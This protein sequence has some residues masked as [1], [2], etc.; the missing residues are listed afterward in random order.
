MHKSGTS[1][2]NFCAPEPGHR[3]EVL[4]ANTWRCNLR[5]S[6]CFVDQRS[7]AK[8][9]EGM[10]RKLA[11]QVIDALDAGLAHIEQICVHFYGGEPLLHLPAIEAMVE[12]SEAKAPGRFTFAITTNGAAASERAVALLGAAD[13]QIVLSVDGPGEVHD[14]CRRT[15]DDQP[16]HS[17]VLAFLAAIRERT[18]CRVRGSAVVRSGWSLAQASAYLRS[19]R[20]D[21]IK[22]QAV[23]AA[24]GAPY[25]L[26]P[27]EQQAYLRDLEAA[28][29]QVIAELEAGRQPKDDRFT[30]RILQ[31]LKGGT[32]D[33]FCGA[34]HT[35][36]G[37]TPMGDVL[38]CLLMSVRDGRLGH[39]RDD[40]ATW[41]QAGRR[42]RERRKQQAECRTCWCRDLC[43]GGCPAMVP[44]CGP[45]EC[46]YTRKHCEVVTAIYEHFC[47][48][49]EK[50][51]ALV[52][53]T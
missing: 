42:W 16:T 30:S 7:L 28:G 47:P 2:T 3:A 11:A 27:D 12:R 39:V 21:V 23:R 14:Q 38:S 17:R 32:R 36:F 20:V 45:D 24:D 46:A 13:F 15:I 1:A 53:I 26:S 50:L 22:A 34:G 10:S 48:T 19:L 49:P 41:V 25:A 40:P 37:I 8:P 35:V 5:C 18:N 52:G 29:R 4:V 44:V 51:L 33:S 6:Y 9:Q 31:L 43:G